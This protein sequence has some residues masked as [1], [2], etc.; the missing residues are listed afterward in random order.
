MEYYVVTV[1]MNI[2]LLMVLFKLFLFI[3]AVIECYVFICSYSLYKEYSTLTQQDGVN[4]VYTT[5]N[6]MIT[7]ENN[8]Q[9]YTRNE[10]DIQGQTAGIDLKQNS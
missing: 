1:G 3:I 10:S 2:L 9:L 8:T 4:V 5:V 7:N 6:T